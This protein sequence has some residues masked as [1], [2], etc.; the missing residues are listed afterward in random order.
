MGAEREMSFACA[1]CRGRGWITP[2]RSDSFPEPCATC[3]GNSTI[4]VTQLAKIL[5]GKGRRLRVATMRQYIRRVEEDRASSTAA[6]HV[7][8]AI[9]RRFPTAL[10]AE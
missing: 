8:R 1:T 10:A 5:V 7:L 9:K 2:A 4:S 3:G 6:A